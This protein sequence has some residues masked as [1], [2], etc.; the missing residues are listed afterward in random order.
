MNKGY[1]PKKESQGQ[2]Y[3]LS[4]P[5]KQA[6]LSTGLVLAEIG[7]LVATGA[8]MED[9]AVFALLLTAKVAVSRMTS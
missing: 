4:K 2:S 6:L 9:Y 1:T 8:T 7:W 5:S 3:S